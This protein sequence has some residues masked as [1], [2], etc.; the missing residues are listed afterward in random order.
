MH[1]LASR[2][3]LRSVVV[4]VLPLLLI[5]AAAS[6]VL[7]DPAVLDWT[8]TWGGPGDHNDEATFAFADLEAGRAY[9]VV[10]RG[11][12]VGNMST[13]A[14]FADYTGGPGG[15]DGPFEAANISAVKV[16]AF[17]PAGAP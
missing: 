4:L 17:G 11:S 13:L 8:D 2:R 1:P 14:H 5:G 3:I 15:V 10:V 12:E 9:R 7:A 16:L 6:A